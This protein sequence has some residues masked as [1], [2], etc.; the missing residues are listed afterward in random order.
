MLLEELTPGT[1][2][3]GVLPADQVTVVAVRPYGPDA[4][5]VTYEVDDG[6]VG[7][8]VLYRH[9]EAALSVA[10][11]Q[12]GAGPA[13][14]GDPVRFRIAAEA[15]RIQMAGQH[16]EML[17]VSTSDLEPL[18]HQI[19]AVYGEL[20]PRIP[21]R[22]LLADDPG[23][24]KTVMAGLY[25]KE[26]VLRGDLAR[27]LVVAPGQLAEQWQEELAEKFGL[28]FT[29]LTGSLLASNGS[30][31]GSAT[32]LFA[33]HP[34]L[35]ARLD[36][37]ARNDE[38]L[39]GLERCEW[40]LV[41][42]DEAHRMSAHYYG[43]ELRT[44]R[45]Y[46]LGRLLSRTTR[47]FLLVTATPH[48]GVDEDFQAFLALLDP[49]RYEGRGRDCPH[50][51]ETFDLMLRRVKEELL[52]F[53]G[54]PL[55]PERRAYTVPY[56]LSVE[57][58]RLYEAVTGYV[59]TEMNRAD[60]LRADGDEA[61]GGRANTVGFAL[62]VLQR[63][64]ASSP[65]AIWSSLCRRHQGLRARLAEMGAPGAPGPV[66]LPRTGDSE[67]GETDRTA[68]P[69]ELTELVGEGESDLS[70]ATGP[71]TVLAASA[72]RT[73][74]ELEREVAT[75]ADL[76]E[77]AHSVRAGGTD[78]KWTELRDLLLS[79]PVRDQATGRP[80]RIV[81]FTEHRD[82][83]YYLMRQVTELL[84]S[85]DAVAAIHGGLSRSRRRAVQARFA[86]DPRCVVLIATD[87]AGEGLNLQQAN[88]M[89][90]YDLPWN[91]NRLEQRFGRI[92][93]IG[94]H[95]VC[96]LWNLVAAETR[97]GDVFLRLLEKVEQQ[98]QAY[99]GK[100]FDVLGEAF[101][102]V[103]LHRL[104]LE[105]IRYG[106]QP[107]VRARLRTVIDERVSEGLERLLTEQAL[108]RDLLTLADVERIRLELEEAKAR[109]LQPHFIRAFFIEA[110]T[111]LG[112]HLG[113]REAGRYEITQ[114]PTGLRRPGLADGR[115]VLPRY[116]RVCFERD[117]LRVPGRPTADL[118]APGHPLFDAVVSRTVAEYRSALE[119]GAVL[120]DRN[121]PG[122]QVR[123]LAAL[124]QEVV[125]GH[126]PGR[127]VY[128]RFGFVEL[129][130]DGTARAVD[131]A[132]Y[133]DYG[134]PDAAEVAALDVAAA[135]WRGGP[136]RDRAVEWAASVD[137]PA[138]L[139]PLR[140]RVAGE[141]R[142]TAR[143]VAERLESEAAH[144]RET[145][146]LGAVLAASGETPRIR[147]ESALARAGDLDRRL[148]RRLTELERETH[149]S[150]RPPLL[151]ASALVVP[152]GLLNR[153][154]GVGS[155]GSPVELDTE[156]DRRAVDAVLLAERRLGRRPEVMAHNNPGFDI[157]SRTPEGHWV[158][159]EV[160]G[161]QRGAESFHVTRTQ[162]LKGKN[163]E[164][165]RLALVELD[166]TER[167]QDRVRYL[168][169]PFDGVEFDDLSITCIT[170]SWSDKWAAGRAPW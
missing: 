105:A 106:E 154:R 56:E 69:A 77:L 41:V 8:H 19:Q 68:E 159:I 25:I 150:A 63:R 123:V 81:V 146:R 53:E 50:R 9:D 132:P 57:E 71:A 20:L 104:L 109:R 125:D 14:D 141:S 119:R 65:E 82:T 126:R 45:R 24:G 78:R 135:H 38:L 42:V 122:E 64:L 5:K 85:A 59:R 87:V 163:A 151:A 52:T 157:R 44:T 7:Q 161:R 61:A 169:Q 147:P 102:E 144:W 148:S 18:P 120:V 79:P 137:L 23:S 164:R 13:F 97:E 101:D 21:L 107:Q 128:K 55:F 11:T 29:L 10:A 94:Q 67:F 116:E 30:S 17:A 113:R 98:R 90:N 60:A 152:Q 103:P 155:S 40:D 35:I 143:L 133:L 165:Y 170:W 22:F 108:H 167:D 96:H 91:P 149:L 142:R 158:F 80:R 84:G 145:A 95:E 89:V 127:T 4:V 2:L 138:Q 136:I 47:N 115:P 121:D 83:L 34:L 39:A 166:P 75:V 140:E 48:A 86:Q 46:E 99:R 118:L 62:T 16:G 131:T 93:R 153:L 51:G 15:L 130:Q 27:C 134:P 58:R 73:V 36:Q 88:L 28:R 66:P 6:G 70:D 129:Y 110:F 49:D 112:G 26:L 33:A 111:R 72:A 76:V 168:D 54:R 124:R 3:T 12:P 139:T 92:H 160:K 37:L 43:N 156:A 114:V 31:G 162:V 32:D 74:E 1:R 100:V 117:R